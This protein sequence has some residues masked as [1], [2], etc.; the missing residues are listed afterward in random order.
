MIRVT[1]AVSADAK[2]LAELLQEVDNFYG[3]PARETIDSKLAN[4][5]SAL[6][7]DPPRAYSLLAWEES[8]LVGFASYSILWPAVMSTKSL[9]LKELYVKTSHRRAGIGRLLMAGIFKAALDEGCS[10]AEWTTD[11]VNQ[12]AQ[13]FYERLGISTLSSKLF[14]RADKDVLRDSSSGP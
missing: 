13:E 3:E 9:Y 12:D 1:R 2:A 14:Y 7:A 11:Q 6:F 10:R 4:I 8:D 5:N